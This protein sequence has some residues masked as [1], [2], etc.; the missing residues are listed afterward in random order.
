MAAVRKSDLEPV[1]M[2][3]SEY[4]RE[5][6]YSQ[7]WTV[8]D[9]VPTEHKLMES[10]GVS[11]GTAQKAIMTLVEHGL[12]ERK[13]GKGTFVAKPVIK[14]PVDKSMLPFS[15]AVKG[16]HSELSTIVYHAEMVPAS[17]TCQ[18]R[19]QIGDGGVFFLQRIRSLNGTPI[20][21]LESRINLAAC[22]HIEAF[23]FSRRRL[24]SAI[25]ITSRHKL[26]K[27]EALY[28]ACTA[29][30]ERA[31]ILGCNK[32][33]P[34]LHIDQVAILDNGARAEWANVWVLENRYV[35]SSSVYRI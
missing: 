21:L 3:I 17:T 26:I 35:A 34:V 14:R 27:T 28:G 7:E 12:L 15:E 32:N 18:E 5:K 25:E 16:E 22:P 33:S 29:G 23:D 1:Y 8:G 31:K 2:Q 19:L 6:I 30:A 24:Y 11:R 4:I 13:Q 10:F 20:M 9:Q